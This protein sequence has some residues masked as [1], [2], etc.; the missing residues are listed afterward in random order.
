LRDFEVGVL[1]LGTMGSMAAWQL[2]KSG[3]SVIGFEQFGIGHDNGAAGGETRIFRTIYKEGSDY[4]PLLQRSKAIWQELEAESGSS[5]LN[6]NGFV[7]IGKKGDEYFDGVMKCMSD[8]KLHAELLTASEANARF[9]ALNVLPEEMAVLDKDGGLIKPERA[10]IAAVGQAKAKGAVIKSRCRVDE[11]APDEDGVWVHTSQGDYRV[12][13]LIIT[14]G[15][16]ANDFV[17]GDIITPHRVALSWFIS[18]RP[19]LFTSEAFPS[20][21][22]NIMGSGI[23]LFSSQDN[24]M[25]KVGVNGSVGR[26]E[27]P[28]A[29]RSASQPETARLSTIIDKYYPDLWPEPVRSASYTDGFTSDEHAIVG[30][31]PGMANVTVAVGFSAHGFK[32][33]PA[34]G[35][36]LCQLVTGSKSEVPLAHLSPS[37]LINKEPVVN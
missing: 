34:I 4:V 33:A 1:G 15:A 7:T 30:D 13:R 25:V 20:S 11:I 6:L 28:E 37:R 22:R 18:K 31:L 2:A 26:L 10:V 29:A 23:S 19:E 16:W 14:A 35:V 36:S 24:T 8:Y 5:L 17:P 27:T 3:V 21:N 9:P 32:M 12:K